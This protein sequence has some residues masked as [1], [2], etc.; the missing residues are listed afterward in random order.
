VLG[1][2]IAVDLDEDSMYLA[3]GAMLVLSF[4]LV[5]LRPERWLRGRE[6]G[7]HAPRLVDGLIF[8]AIGVYGGF[9]QAG[10]GIFL[11]IGLVLNMGFDIVRGNAVKSMLVLALNLTAFV[12]FV[13]NGQV[14]WGLGLLLA[15]GQMAGAWV[16]AHVAMK[17]WAHVWVYRLLLVVIVLSAVQMFMR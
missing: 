2:L 1:A 7:A 3:I 16:A 13:R 12:V 15:I 17:E 6:G 14:N 4:F 11:L 10:V 8:L 5:L 9:I